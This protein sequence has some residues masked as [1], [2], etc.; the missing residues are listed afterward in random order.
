MYS[1]GFWLAFVWPNLAFFVLATFSRNFPL[2][3]I[4]SNSL[5]CLN[6]YLIFFFWLSMQS[7]LV[8]IR[9]ISTVTH[10]GIVTLGYMHLSALESVL[11]WAHLRVQRTRDSQ[12]LTLFITQVE[13]L[14]A[15]TRGCGVRACQGIGFVILA[16]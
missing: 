14:C 10:V 4:R 11:L 16:S 8:I 13:H 15:S 9:H 6:Y 3:I 1:L 5:L 2:K 12:C 7:L